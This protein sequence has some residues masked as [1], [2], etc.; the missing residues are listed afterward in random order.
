LARKLDDLVRGLGADTDIS[1]SEG[2]RIRA[3]FDVAVAIP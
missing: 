2:T 1:K 3:K